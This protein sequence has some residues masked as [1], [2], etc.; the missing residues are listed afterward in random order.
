[1]IQTECQEA[2][3]SP[4]EGDI[5]GPGL[6]SRGKGKGGGTDSMNPYFDFVF[7]QDGALAHTSWGA[8]M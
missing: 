1:M 2:L 5:I 3:G 6:V 8:Q 7:R 4:E